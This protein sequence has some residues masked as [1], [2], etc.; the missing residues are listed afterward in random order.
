MKTKKFYIE[1]YGCQMNEADSELV[2]GLLLKKSYLPANLPEEADII[3]V[4]TCSVR[5]NAERRAIA[6]LSQFKNLKKVNPD[7]LIGIIGC[8]AQRY[9]EEI[10]RENPFI[11]IALGPDSYRKLPDAI[12]SASFP[13]TGFQLSKKEVYDGLLPFRSSRVNAWISI[14]RGCDKFCAYCIVPFTR[15]RERSRSLTGIV[16]EVKQ[17]VADGH[18]EVTLLGQNVNSYTYEAFRFPELLEAVSA[19]AGLKRIRYTSPH[20]QDFDDRLLEVMRDHSNI[21]RHIHL[22]L[23]SGSTRI[24]SLMRR[25]YDQARYL[26]LVENIRRHMPDCAITTDIIVGFPQETE[27]DFSETLKV[28]DIVV[29]DAAYNFKYSPR[30]GTL[31]AKMVDNV[32]PEEK[33]DRL[34]R[35]IEKQKRHTLIRNSVLVGTIQELLVDSVSRKNPS[36]KI[37][38]TGTNKI[39]IIQKGNPEIR[40]VVRVRIEKAIGISLFGTIV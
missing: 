14:M 12:D 17:A 15:G 5:E 4:N 23:Q 32:T 34:N 30:P 13:V 7:L 1:T 9:R 19:V 3:L 27:A 22:P 37:G 31:A 11:D 28:M 39:V 2:A 16:D 29:F 25:N 21:C 33:S 10:I 38:R 18:S 36:E 35:V 40:E 20:P 24:L 8:V 6:R 26:S